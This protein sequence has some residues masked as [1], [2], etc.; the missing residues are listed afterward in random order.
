MKILENIKK[1]INDFKADTLKLD[2]FLTG[3]CTSYS[4]FQHKYPE[5]KKEFNEK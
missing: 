5:V 3:T 1:N 4:F 2:K